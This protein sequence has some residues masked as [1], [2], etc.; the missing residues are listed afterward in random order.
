MPPLGIFSERFP[1][2]LLCS[3]KNCAVGSYLGVELVVFQERVG[4]FPPAR[5][6]FQSHIP[7]GR[8]AGQTI[9]EYLAKQR[10]IISIRSH[11][12]T[13]HVQVRVRVFSTIILDTN[14]GGLNLGSIMT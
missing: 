7:C 6:L 1:T 11:L 2:L 13:E 9:R 3:H 14:F 4:H 5:G 8:R 10:V 12:P